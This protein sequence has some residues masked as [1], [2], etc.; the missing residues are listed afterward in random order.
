VHERSSK[1]LPKNLN[2]LAYEIVRLSPEEP[3][4]RDPVSKYL[5]EIRRNGELKKGGGQWQRSYRPKNIRKS[6]RKQHFRMEI[7]I[8][9]I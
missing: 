6:R 4:E 9:D 7:I 1:P 3:E 8:V 5:S 2:K